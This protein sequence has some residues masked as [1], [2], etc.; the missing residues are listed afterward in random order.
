MLFLSVALALVMMIWTW[1]NIR[2]VRI[3]YEVAKLEREIGQLRKENTRLLLERDK[4]RDFDRIARRA[5]T[6]LGMGYPNPERVFV[7]SA[8]APPEATP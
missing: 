6:E 2:T 4:A 1:S 3:G 7:V 5:V 8:S